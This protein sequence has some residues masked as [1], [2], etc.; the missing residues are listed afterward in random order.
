VQVPLAT[1]LVAVLCG[2]V[3][4]LGPSRVEAQT[5]SGPIEEGAAQGL[6]PGAT[7][8]A[9]FRK[10]TPPRNAF[11]PY[12]SWDAH[13]AM[14]VTVVR[15]GRGALAFSSMFQSVGT[16]NIRKRVSVGGTGYLLGLRYVHTR[17][18]RFQ[19][20]SGLS[21]FS[22]HLTRDL[23]D[24]TDEERADGARIPHVEDPSEFNVLYVSGRWMWPGRPLTPELH[25]AIQP[26]NFRFDGRHADYVRPVYLGTRWTLWRGGHQSIMAETQQEIGRDPFI[27]V[28]LVFALYR[29]DQADS[30]FQAFVSGSPGGQVRVS[31]QIGALRGGFAFGIR[32]KFR[33]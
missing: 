18:A 3:C 4:L 25:L 1:C 28:A 31:P 33:A 19:L 7:L 5:A 20:S 12:Y 21:H 14:D 29:S 22:S 15:R 30:R 8:D 11:S 2:A 16:E 13:L 26:I 9:A 24:K 27:D 17:S 32:M 23:D 10:Y 6:F